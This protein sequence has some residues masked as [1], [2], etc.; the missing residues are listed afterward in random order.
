M[1]EIEK[2]IILD[3]ESPLKKIKTHLDIPSPSN[4]IEL[5][6]WSCGKALSSLSSSINKAKLSLSLIDFEF[7]KASDQGDQS[8]SAY[9]ELI[10]E[11]SIIRVQSIYDRVLILV[12]KILNIG[13][14]NESISHNSIVTN[15]HTKIWKIDSHLKKLNKLCSE[16][17][18]IRNT[19]IH[20]DRYNE[21][22]LNQLTLII[23]A[24]YLSKQDGMESPFAESKIQDITNAYLQVK[25]EEL[26]KY[27]DQ[28]LEKLFEIYDEL[29][30]IYKY[31]KIKLSKT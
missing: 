1:H 24:D 30:P 22:Q 13:L 29:I 27:L 25:K 16:Y 31:K 15:D 17:R 20:H 18:F 14:A 7:I 3:E 12:N 2:I 26:D 19:V 10:I 6:V 8:K 9:I 5:Y 4:F 11:N 28:I 23:E 21:E